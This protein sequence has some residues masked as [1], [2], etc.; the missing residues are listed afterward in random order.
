M[1]EVVPT[2]VFFK[3]SV[4]PFTATAPVEVNPVV[5][6]GDLLNVIAVLFDP[7]TVRVPFAV[8]N[9]FMLPVVSKPLCDPDR[10]FIVPA[11]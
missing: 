8:L 11:D 6:V 7:P 2:R 9:K 4:V 1:V 5:K 10:I 3:V